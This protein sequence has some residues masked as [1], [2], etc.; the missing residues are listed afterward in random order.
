[1]TSSRNDDAILDAAKQCVLAVG[2]RRTT[3]AEIARRAGVSR[4]TVYRRWPDVRTLSADLLTRELVALLPADTGDG[5][6]RHGL[7]RIVRTVSA[8]REH[9]LFV[10]ILETDPELL[11]TYVFD[12]LGAS[13]HRILELLTTAIRS[14]QADRT[15]RSGDPDELA[16]MVLLLVQS[17]VLSARIVSEALPPERLDAQLHTVLDAYLRPEE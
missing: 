2:M 1:M 17:A 16:A 3:L 12:R 5:S 4:P 13:Q 7:D 8:A 14:G 6:R 10:K 15:I 9:P 11:T